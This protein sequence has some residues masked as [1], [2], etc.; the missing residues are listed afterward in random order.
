MAGKTENSTTEPRLSA[1]TT[2]FLQSRPSIEA[3]SRVLFRDAAEGQKG[4]GA[5]VAQA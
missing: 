2:R 4:T 3:F 1:K 5:A